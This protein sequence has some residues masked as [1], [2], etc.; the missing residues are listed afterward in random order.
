V[1]VRGD[2]LDGGLEV[3]GVPQLDEGGHLFGA[4]ER[5]VLGEWRVHSL[6]PVKKRISKSGGEREGK[7]GWKR[8]KEKGRYL[9]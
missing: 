9:S 2:P 5:D 8:R 4:V 1:P 6:I 7:K 3:D